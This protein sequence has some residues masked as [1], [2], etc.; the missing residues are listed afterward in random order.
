MSEAEVIT[1]KPIA[2]YIPFRAQLAELK[3]TNANAV[4]DYE[5][6]QGNKDARS[7]VYK[8]RKTKTA[9]EKARKDEKQSSLEY[10]RKVDDEAREIA[11]EVEK[12]IELHDKP[13]KAI[14]QK[15]KDRKAAIQGRYD[16][17]V[18]IRQVQMHGDS[19]LISEHIGDLKKLEPDD[20]FDEYMAEATREFKL[21]MQYLQD[22]LKVAETAEAERAE[23]E[24]LREEQAA[25]EQ[26]EREEQIAKDATA[27]AEREA[28][29]KIEQAEREKQQAIEREEQLKRD[30]EAAE[31]R[32][33]DDQK[34]A[35]EDQKKAVAEAEERTKREAEQAEIREREEADKREANRKHKATVNNEAID[36]L[37]AG[38]ISK[39]A[40]KAVV[41]LIAKR[42][43]P[44]VAISY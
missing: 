29:Q 7:H 14:E 3:E 34:Q 19:E 42:E 9:I 21:S 1:D 39:T 22:A 4:F 18:G 44:N 40:A 23:L 10:G 43:I 6:P 16:E 17:I 41:T 20:T 36:A 13:L 8:L 28:R 5:D 37:V 32:R 25:R 26:K 12:M 31:Q 33:I 24:R 15:E 27:M 35:E 38:G 11:S 2:A 30:A